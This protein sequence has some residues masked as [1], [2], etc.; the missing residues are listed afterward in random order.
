MLGAVMSP[1]RTAAQTNAIPKVSPPQSNGFCERFHQTV[2]DEFLKIQFRRKIYQS[3]PELREDLNQFLEFYNYQRAHQGYRVKGRT[4]MKALE[5]YL[6][7]LRE[8]VKQAA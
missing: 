1:F 5:D 3:L 6:E 2:A 8:E 4:P 7:A